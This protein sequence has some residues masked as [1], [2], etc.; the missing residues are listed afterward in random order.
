MTIVL[1]NVRPADGESVEM[2]KQ[3]KG[4][5]RNRNGVERPA[6]T[7]GR[8][9][10]EQDIN[11][12]LPREWLDESAPAPEPRYV[13]ALILHREDWPRSTT[14]YGVLDELLSQLWRD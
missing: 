5:Q 13:T 10:R 8:T 12:T 11:R 7:P 4:Q 3:K 1:T 14:G 2:G 9:K 6:W